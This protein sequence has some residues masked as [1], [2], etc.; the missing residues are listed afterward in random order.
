MEAKLVEYFK[1]Y[2]AHPLGKKLYYQCQDIHTF[3]GS[4]D[5][6]VLTARLKVGE[7]TKN[8]SADISLEAG[9]FHNNAPLVFYQ[10]NI[11]AD[12]VKQAYF[13]FITMGNHYDSTLKSQPYI[14]TNYQHSMIV[15]LEG[16]LAG[17]VNR[18]ELQETVYATNKKTIRDMTV[19]QRH[20]SL[21][22]V[23]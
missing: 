9:S 18:G 19:I 14:D 11:L 21:S 12:G 1:P 10:R 13:K 7:M 15:P 23:K 5:S 6:M 8:P 2:M 4:Y 3:Q 17:L 22:L 16:E 20:L